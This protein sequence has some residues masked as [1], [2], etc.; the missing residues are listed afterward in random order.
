MIDFNKIKDKV[1]ENKI[2]IPRKDNSIKYKSIIF[3][4]NGNEIVY[5]GKTEKKILE[6][7]I[8]RSNK[9]QSTHYFTELVELNDFDNIMAELILTIQPINH[10]KIPKNTKYISHHKAKE[11]YHISKTEFKKYW[12]E[13]NGL[14]FRK[15]LFLEKKVFNDI[16]L[17]LPYSSN[18]PK[19]GTLINTIEDIENTPI[20]EYGQN[21]NYSKE[22]TKDGKIVE[23]LITTYDVPIKQNYNNLQTRLKHS[24]EVISLLDSY[25]FEAYSKYKNIKRIF[26]VNDHTWKKILPKYEQNSIF[27]KY[28]E[29]L[30]Q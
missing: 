20:D 30:N 27:N 22:K 8:E 3:F 29:S 16:F 13:Y 1:I 15:T 7:V 4:L 11:E 17:K 18:M 28:Y 10:N 24:F 25:R 12:K 19:I 21:Q 5:I 2:V 14:L 9:F 23:T 26:N 6:Y